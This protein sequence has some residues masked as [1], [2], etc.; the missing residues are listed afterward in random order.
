MLKKLTMLKVPV[1]PLN[2]PVDYGAWHLAFRRLVKGYN[3]GDALMFTIPEDRVKAFKTRAEITKIKLEEEEPSARPYIQAPIIQP[4]APFQPHP[5]QQ[6]PRE[7]EEEIREQKEESKKGKKDKG[8]KTPA[9][10]PAKP[11]Q[12]LPGAALS[13]VQPALSMTQSALFDPAPALS[14][15]TPFQ[16]AST[17]FR[18]MVFDDEPLDIEP[19]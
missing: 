19:E 9:Q 4:Q 16:P 14:S 2:N 11:A 13:T 15:A 6:F 17:P 3:M 5:A 7:E 12:T 1:V 8:N 10:T 18:T